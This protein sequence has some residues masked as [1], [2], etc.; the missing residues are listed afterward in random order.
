M[1]PATAPMAMTPVGAAAAP[2]ERLDAAAAV[3]EAME[4]AEPEA[5]DIMDMEAMELMLM[6]AMDPVLME[7]MTLADALAALVRPETAALAAE[8]RAGRAIHRACLARRA[9][10]P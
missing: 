2:D 3:D 10:R 8:L 4:A 1:R 9:G 6:L 7:L 5:E